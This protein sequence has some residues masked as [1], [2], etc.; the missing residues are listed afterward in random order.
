MNADRTPGAGRRTA[1]QRALSNMR[2]SARRTLEL[3]ILCGYVRAGR[4][5][6]ADKSPVFQRVVDHPLRDLQG[7][8]AAIAS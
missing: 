6:P 1:V 5:N 3:S 8:R 4:V 2:Q 7:E